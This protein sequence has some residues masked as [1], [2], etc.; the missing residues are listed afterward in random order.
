MERFG[1]VGSGVMGAGIAEIGAKGGCRVIVVDAEDEALE[2]A[3]HRM[4]SSL[5]KA[6]SQ[7]K[8]IESANDVLARITWTTDLS[9]L[10]DR[11]IVTEAIREQLEDKIALIETLNSILPANAIITSNTSSI[12]ITRL[13]AASRFPERLVGT[14]FFNPVPIMPLVEL[15]PALQTAPEVLDRVH[16][17]CSDT[18]AK[19]VIRAK[20]RSGFLVN[21]LLV[22]YLLDAIRSLEHGDATMEDIDEGMVSGCGMP[23]GPLRLCDMIG[24]DTL[25]LVADSLY[26]EHLEPRFTPPALLQ[27]YVE[28]GRFGKKSGQGFY[29]YL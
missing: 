24:L 10:A 25:A 5:S 3:Q 22:P 6:E 23:M 2:R 26:A 29:T 28:A 4:T 12:P 18:L 11:D 9:A 7:G 16:Q 21:A 20:D 27:R 1:V 15:V 19:K 14:H 13:A 8:L 17:F